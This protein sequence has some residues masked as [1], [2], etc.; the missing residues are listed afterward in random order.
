MAKGKLGRTASFRPYIVPVIAV[1][2]GFFLTDVLLVRAIRG[3]FFQ[4]LE[5]Q[6]INYAQIYSH[7]LTK[8]R[9]AYHI[10]NDLLEE[11]LF[12]A[13]GTTALYSAHMTSES[14]AELAGVLGVDEIYIYNGEGEIIHSTREE[15]LGWRAQPG[16]PVHDFLVSGATALVEDIREDTESGE[17]FKYG[18][19]RGEEGRFVQLGIRA[20]RVAA[21]LES[22]EVGYPLDELSNLELVDQV[23]FVDAGFTIRASDNPELVGAA[24]EDPAVLAAL[25]AG[26]R[27]A[28]VKFDGRRGAWSPP[29][30]QSQGG[31]C[32]AGG[33]GHHRRRGCRLRH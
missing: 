25:A 15:Y 24:V 26:E 1:V 19:F 5:T 17:L 22:F 31:G 10:I 11:K 12:S 23:S 3:Y 21:L 20:D 29:L 6:S 28:Q 30:P 7:S 8:S 9:E 16:H 18:Y 13:S 14:L 2:L 32:E 33:A 4:L 27:Y